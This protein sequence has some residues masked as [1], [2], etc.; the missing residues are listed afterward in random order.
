MSNALASFLQRTY[1]VIFRQDDGEVSG[2][3]FYFV[4]RMIFSGFPLMRTV[5]R[6]GAPEEEPC[7]IVAETKWQHASALCI[8]GLGRSKGQVHLSVIAFSFSPFCS[9]SLLPHDETAKS[10]CCQLFSFAAAEWS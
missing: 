3:P 1:M 6:V 9:L 4:L 5:C 8:V 2:K 7:S 10:L